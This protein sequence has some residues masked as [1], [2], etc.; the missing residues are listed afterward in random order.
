MTNEN[1]FRVGLKLIGVLV[2]INEIPPLFK[3][4]LQLL[5]VLS[6]ENFSEGFIVMFLGFLSTAVIMAFGYY[7]I[8]GDLEWLVKRANLKPIHRSAVGNIRIVP[9]K[10][11][12]SE[13]EGL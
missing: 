9:R 1:L 10:E 7:M 11:E 5:S 6:I 12:S 2:I 4:A 13:T 8:T 3:Q